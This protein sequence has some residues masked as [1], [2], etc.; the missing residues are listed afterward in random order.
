MSRPTALGDHLPM[1]S[2]DHPFPIHCKLAFAFG[3][4]TGFILWAG[5]FLFGALNSSTGPSIKV[6]ALALI[7]SGAFA[8]L[9]H[10][11]FTRIPRVNTGVQKRA[12]ANPSTSHRILRAGR[13]VVYVALG[14]AGSVP[15]GIFATYVSFQLFPSLL[16]PLLFTSW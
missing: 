3:T 15:G 14:L 4:L 6:F 9:S 11:V 7:I 2:F 5:F 12:I 8:A 10:L 13:Y 16:G 1:A